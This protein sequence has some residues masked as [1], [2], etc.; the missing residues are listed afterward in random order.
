MRFRTFEATQVF[1]GLGTLGILYGTMKG[2][3][4]GPLAAALLII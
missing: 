2:E 3:Y 1:L 4:L